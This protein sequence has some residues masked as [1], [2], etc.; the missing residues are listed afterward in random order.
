MIWRSFILIVLISTSSLLHGQIQDIANNVLLLRAE[1]SLSDEQRF[2]LD[3]LWKALDFYRKFEQ[4]ETRLNGRAAFGFTGNASDLNQIFKIHAGV[5]IDKGLYPLELDL[6]SNYQTVIKNGVFE[7][8][9]S[10]IDISM[11]YHPR[12]G[13]GLFLETFVFL[14]RFNNTYLGIDQR[15]E[16][17]T[18]VIFNLYSTENL[19][20][21][22]A[23]NRNNLS[24]LRK[25]QL[26]DGSLWKC[27]H[28]CTNIGS[29]GKYK[30]STDQIQAIDSKRY[31]YDKANKKKYAKWRIALLV[32]VY[33]ENEKARLERQI[34]FNEVPT[35]FNTAF[36]TTNKL[37]WELRP[38]IVY[39]PDDIFTFRLYPYFKFPLT[40]VYDIVRYDEQTF[41]KRLD[42]F[43]DIQASMSMRIH[44]NIAV[45]IRYRYL[46]DLAPKRMYLLDANNL[47]TLII[48]QEYNNYY[49]IDFSFGF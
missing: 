29:L 39:K 42:Q 40:Q 22:G 46:R 48:G 27:Y 8:N 16:A 3:T 18:G 24:K 7:E 19:T 30:L 41:D 47:P 35:V 23:K 15:F 14:K 1:K 26:V 21:T 36:N 45:G 38:T 37:R 4:R 9:V 6:K 12:V 43:Y 10:D 28:A 13:N 44:R 17:G 49:N 31:D 33:Y 34:L 11:D 5:S 25:Y 32:G 20:P 2:E